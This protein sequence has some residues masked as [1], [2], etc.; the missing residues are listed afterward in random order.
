MKWLL[1]FSFPVLA[2]LSVAGC[3]ES[4]TAK[5]AARSAPNRQVVSDLD[6]LQG[7]WRIESSTWNGVDDPEI[8]KSVTII[9]QGDKFVLVDR[10][11]I[12]QTETIQLMPDQNPKS[13]DCTSQTRGRLLPG[14]YSLEGDVFKWCSA[15][16]TNTLRPINFSSQPGSKQSLMVLRRAKN[17]ARTS[18]QR[19]RPLGRSAP[20]DKTK[21]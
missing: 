12:P 13:I 7:T 6:K 3:S 19:T 14:I 2:L 4:R 18:D 15:G 21:L 5:V 10:D 1:L 9:F 17:S 11:G 20:G 8:F 16:G